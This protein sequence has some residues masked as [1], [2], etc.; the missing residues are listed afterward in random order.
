MMADEEGFME[1]DVTGGEGLEVGQKVG[2]LSGAVIRILKWAALAL[3]AI[4]FVVTIVVVTMNI[5]G[6]N[7]PLAGAIPLSTEMTGPPPTYSY[8]K[9]IPELRARTGDQNPVTVIVEVG[10]GYKKDDNTISTQLVERMD[11]LH[12]TIRRFFGTKT[13]AELTPANEDKVKEE[14][15]R[16]LND[17]MGG[18]PI[19]D[20]VFYQ[21]NT[22]D[23]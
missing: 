17:V 7:N 22:V 21:Y 2:F 6:A 16:L 1:E 18:S 10:L 19:Q 12:D 13:K 4:I 9:A 15:R 8:F 14:L 3:A 5:V 11:Q 20:I 23:F